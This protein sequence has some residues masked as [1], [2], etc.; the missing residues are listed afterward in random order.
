MLSKFQQDKTSVTWQTKVCPY[1]LGHPAYV[2]RFGTEHYTAKSF[3]STAPSL[4]RLGYHL[5]DWITPSVESYSPQ[6]LWDQGIAEIF[7]F[8][9]SKPGYMPS[10]TKHF[11]GQRPAKN[12][13]QIPPGENEITP[14]D[15]GMESNAPPFHCTTGT[16]L[17]SKH[18]T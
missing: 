2:W 5:R 1:F 9:H 14:A 16:T 12:P 4:V 10:T 3:H 17:S 15:L 7:T 13:A 6:H 8:L 11:Y 18:G